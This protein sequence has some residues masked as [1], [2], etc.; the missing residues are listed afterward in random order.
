MHGAGGHDKIPAR[1][2]VWDGFSDHSGARCCL[3]TNHRRATTDRRILPMH[4][5]IALRDFVERGATPRPITPAI[6]AEDQVF[7]NA[8]IPIDNHCFRRCTFLK[9]TLWFAGGPCEFE[10][11]QIDSETTVQLT[12]AA[13]RGHA[14]WDRLRRPREGDRDW[15]PEAT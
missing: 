7:E 14:L 3:S 1:A 5:D 13:G 8:S 9:S 10:D 2:N 6:Q 11:C 4:L 12:G 15:T